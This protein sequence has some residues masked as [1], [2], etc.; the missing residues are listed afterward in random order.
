MVEMLK[1]IAAST[2]VPITL[3]DSRLLTI[4]LLAFAGFLRIEEVAGIRCCDVSFWEVHLELHIESSKTD[5]Y[6]QGATVAIARSKTPMI[7]PVG[8]L[9]L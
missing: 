2:A 1:W 8:W 5:K 7:C 4:S 3:T 9:D 6:R